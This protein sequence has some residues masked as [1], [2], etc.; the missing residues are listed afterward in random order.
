MRRARK[1]E[2]MAYAMGRNPNTAGSSMSGGL[3]LD[4]DAYQHQLV[5][6]AEVQPI[7]C[8]CSLGGIQHYVNPVTCMQ[9][10][11]MS[12]YT[13]VMNAAGCH[14]WAARRPWLLGP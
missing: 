7:V 6:A 1:A 11:D 2:L 4:L 5:S 8:Q 13:G 14:S 3:L 9:Q 12:V 10:S